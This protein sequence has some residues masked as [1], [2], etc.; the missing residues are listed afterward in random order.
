MRIPRRDERRAESRYFVA[1]EDGARYAEAAPALVERAVGVPWYEPGNGADRAALVLCRLRRA[2]AGELGRPE[3]GDE[4]VR[5]ALSGVSE[6]ALVWLASRAI[7]YMDES[8]YPEAVEA[9]F[10]DE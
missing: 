9:W 7:S 4:A 6:A 1:A 10:Q 3:A 8:G 5:L 2:R